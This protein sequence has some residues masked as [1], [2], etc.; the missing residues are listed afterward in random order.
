MSEKLKAESAEMKPQL[1]DE[2][3]EVLKKQEANRSALLH[4][5]A[6]CE[7]QKNQFMQAMT[8]LLG[9]VEKFRG[10][11]VEKYGKINVNLND[12]TYEVEE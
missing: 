4:D 10:E 5:I 8:Q 12:G 3:L 9:E 7:V 1:T 11:I 2:E 6:I